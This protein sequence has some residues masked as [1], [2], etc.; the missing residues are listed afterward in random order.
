[1]EPLRQIL[2]QALNLPAS[3]LRLQVRTP[4]AYQSN[5]TYRA[6]AWP[7]LDFNTE[8]EQLAGVEFFPWG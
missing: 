1:M 2:S 5:R 3:T 4:L 6:I 7:K 8:L